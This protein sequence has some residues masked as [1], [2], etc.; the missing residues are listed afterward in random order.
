[1]QK[2][3]LETEKSDTAV[4]EG[5]PRKST[6]VHLEVRRVNGCTRFIA[7]RPHFYAFHRDPTSFLTTELRMR[8]FLCALAIIAACFAAQ[9]LAQFDETVMEVNGDPV[10][11]TVDVAGRV[12]LIPVGT[13]KVKGFR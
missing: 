13:D 8:F 6:V 4:Q 2:C 7:I 11:A 12:F 5:A 9:C 1:M 3:N 10:H